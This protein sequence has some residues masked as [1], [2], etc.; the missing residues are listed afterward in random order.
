[1]GKMFWACPIRRRPWDRCLGLPLD[2][3]EEADGEMDFS[4]DLA[5]DEVE[6]VGW[7]V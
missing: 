2:K 3:L 1:M 6:E 5:L 4:H 7:M